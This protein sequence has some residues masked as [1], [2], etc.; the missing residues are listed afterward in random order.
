MYH[1]S[2]LVGY[3]IIEPSTGDIPQIGVVPAHR[4]RG[5][6]THILA[7]LLA[8]FF[9]TE[10]IKVVNVEVGCTSLI[11]FLEEFNVGNAGGQYEMRLHL[12][13]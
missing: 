1:D 12:H 13:A 9:Q 4:R 10:Y 5:L 8:C 11:S 7:R 3:G 6:G 2:V